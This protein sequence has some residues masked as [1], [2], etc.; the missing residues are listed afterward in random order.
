MSNR[1]TFL[2]LFKFS[3]VKTW[4]RQSKKKYYSKSYEEYKL[5]FERSDFLWS[6]KVYSE[7][8]YGDDG[9]NSTSCFN[10]DIIPRITSYLL[11]QLMVFLVFLCVFLGIG[12]FGLT[13]LEFI[14]SIIASF[15]VVLYPLF[16]F[17]KNYKVYRIFRV[18]L[19]R[20]NNEEKI[21]EKEKEKELNDHV[22]KLINSKLEPNVKRAKKLKNLNNIFRD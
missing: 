14:K 7:N 9:Y 21:L 20:C 19:Y 15:I 1:K 6:C 22:V 4:T 3:D 12:T 8:R 13:F 18:V 11:I 16:Y 17:I 2:K 10:C 5:T